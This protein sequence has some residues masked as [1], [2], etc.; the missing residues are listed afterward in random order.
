M[1]DLNKQI[2]ELMELL[3]DY[4]DAKMSVN[5]WEREGRGPRQRSWLHEREKHLEEVS[6]LL[7][8]KLLELTGGNKD[9]TYD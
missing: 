4:V 2:D 1:S 3:S 6:A 8:N 5:Y 9:E 7:R